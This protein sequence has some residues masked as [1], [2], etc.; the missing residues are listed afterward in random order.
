MWRWLYERYVVR[1]RCRR[2]LHRY[3]DDRPPAVVPVG[4]DAADVIDL[5]ALERE[6]A[7][8]AVPA[9]W[10]APRAR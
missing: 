5:T 6:D 8:R 4:S 2:M 3:V 1:P 10:Q 9:T 7:D